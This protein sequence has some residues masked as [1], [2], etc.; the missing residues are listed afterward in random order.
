M[1]YRAIGK[2]SSS[3]QDQVSAIGL[4]TVKIGRNQQVKYPNQFEIPNDQAVLELLNTARELGINLLDTAPAYG[5]SEQRLGKLLP[6]IGNRHDWHIMSKAGEEFENG[7]SSF[8]FTPE[9][10]ELSIKRSLKRL[11][12]DYLDT[13]LIHS[14][15]NDIELIK[16]LGVLEVLNYLK[17]KGLIRFSGIS[18]KTVAGGLL[19]LEQSDAVMVA[20]NLEDHSQLPVIEKANE[21]EKNIFIK[22]VFAS[23][24]RCS[25]EET[26]KLFNEILAYSS[27]SSIVIGTINPAHL[28]QN[29][30]LV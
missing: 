6:Q 19:A 27:V 3:Q 28:K 7:E 16:N 20:Y 29:V 21:L 8:N 11:N 1:Q 4:G 5:S 14:D 30:A 22:K 17:Q 9:H 13:V 25:P 23:G 10:I 15:G 18:T 2:K 12:T 26:Q 24:H